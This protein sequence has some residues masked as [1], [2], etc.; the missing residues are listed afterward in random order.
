M[1]TITFD[2]LELVDRLKT[3]GFQ[4]EQADAVVRVIAASHN[5][6]ATIRDI[7][8]E[9]APIQTD[10]TLLKWMM[11]VILAGIAAL[12]LKGFFPV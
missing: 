5:G 10:L 3:A 12:I 2:T 11:G 7:K 1:T 9:L 4:S 8:I 6:L